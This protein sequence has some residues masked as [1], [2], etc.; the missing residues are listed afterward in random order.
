MCSTSEVERIPSDCIEQDD[1]CG[2][3][4]AGH[5]MHWIHARHVGESP[6]GWRDGVIS[7]VHG[8]WLE[9]S[10]VEDGYVRVWHHE[11]LAD[12]TAGTPV[13]VHERYHALGGPFGWLNVHAEGGLGDVP[14]PAEAWLWSDE[15]TSGVV[16][17]SSGRA[18]ALDHLSDED[19]L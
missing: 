5:L 13:R 16:D 14:E 9:V 2:S 4:G 18:I 1:R 17:N 11:V 8:R 10:Y 19:E 3:Y 12:L 6:W 15:M 7:Y